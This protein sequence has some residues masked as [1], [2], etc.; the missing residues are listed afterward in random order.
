M[1]ASIP[2]ASSSSLAV[3]PIPGGSGILPSH[4]PGESGDPS[5]GVASTCDASLLP[6]AGLASA[7]LAPTAVLPD[8]LMSYT[9]PEVVRSARVLY[10]GVFLTSES[11]EVLVSMVP[12]VHPL[13]RGDHMTLVYMPS[14]KQLLQ[15]P[16]GAEVQVRVLG[17]AANA[18]VQ[19]VFVEAPAWLETS[20]A[21]AH[22][23]ISVAAG[24]QAVEAGQ[25][26]CDALQEAALASTADWPDATAAAAGGGAP[27]QHFDEPLPLVGRLGVRLAVPAAT[28]ASMGWSSAAGGAGRAAGGEVEV[29][30]YSADEL[31]GCGCFEINRDAL[32][33]FHRQH[34][35][36][37]GAQVGPCG[38][39]AFGGDCMF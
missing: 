11:R 22:I 6:A 34:G 19:A 2:A 36:L 15:F 39:A 8:G 9:S 13:L 7:P 17:S 37:L 24:A 26:I 14:V 28:A 3:S 35:H 18:R 20:S 31:A 1:L 21:S 33:A 38:T 10:V 5:A 25:L 23:T 29:V 12:A 16:V 4:S 32:E 27:Y 30:V